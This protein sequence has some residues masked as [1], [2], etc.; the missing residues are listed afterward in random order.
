MILP[1]DLDALHGRRAARWIRESTKAQE[2]RY[3]PDAQREHQG[4]AIERYDLIDTGLVWQVAHSGRTVDQTAEWAEMLAHAGRGYNV[5]VVAYVSRFA[6]NVEALARTIRQLHAAGT[7]VYFCDERLLSSDEQHWDW[8]MREAVEAESYS[9]RLSRRVREGYESKW[10]RHRDPGGW[11]PLGFRREPEPPR[12][13]I[14]DPGTI[15]LA[16]NLFERYATGTVSM[17]DLAAETGVH[18]DA[19]R[20]I[21]CHPIYNGWVRRRGEVDR[22]APWRSNPPVSDELCER[23]A[24]VRAAKV[25]GGGPHR[26]ERVDILSGLLYCTCGRYVRRDGSGRGRNGRRWHQRYHPD[27]CARWGSVQRRQER[28]YAEPIKAQLRGLDVSEPTIVQVIEALSSTVPVPDDMSN[29]R[30]E[31][32][33]KELALDYAS[34]KIS[35][36]AFLSAVGALNTEPDPSPQPLES[37]TPAAVTGYL[38]D[39]HR[40][41]SDI[42]DAFGAGDLSEHEVEAAWSELTH[43]VYRRIRVEGASFTGI[44]LTPAAYQHGLALALPEEVRISLWRARPDSNRRSPA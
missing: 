31:R 10:R 9:R 4:R 20:E 37:V 43:A 42:E 16:V 17:A 34:G 30:R 3:G 39:L 5:L 2:D 44:E 33:R 41:I 6:R 36:P 8:Y 7:A 25:R 21:L 14:I 40:T 24:Q 32:Q 27:P 28:F 38:R 22:P 15:G 35:E 11:A 29:A 12:R 26:W 23:V 19:I 1:A 13:L 18:E